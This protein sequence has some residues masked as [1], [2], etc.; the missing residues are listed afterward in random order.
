MSAASPSV[1]LNGPLRFL[2]SVRLERDAHTPSAL[3]GYTLTAQARAVLRRM[4]EALGPQGTERAWTLTGP[5]GSGKSAFALFLTQLLNAPTGEGYALLQ[6]ADPALADEWRRTTPRPFLP[7]ALTLRR[8][9][10]A[11]A[12][13]EGLQ[14]AAVA[15]SGADTDA[16][17]IGLAGLRAQG[18]TP[19]SRELLRQLEG[20]QGLAAAQGYGGVVLVLDELGKALEYAGRFEGEDIYL[21]QELAEVAARSGPRPLLF[22][23]VLHQAFEHYGEHLIAS[24]RKEWAKVQG[25]FADIA[26]L[27]PPEQQM[28]LAAQAMDALSIRPARDLLTQ[29]SAAAEGIAALG[30]APRALGNTEFL[31]LARSAAPLHPTVLLA[32]PYLFRRFAQNERSLFAYLLSGEPHAV[33]DLWPARAAL[34]RLADLFDYFALNLLGS[35]S[36]QAFARRWLEVV[37]AV[38]RH[39]DL[40]ELQVQTLKTVGLLGV[41]GDVS[42]LVPGAELISLALRDTAEDPEVARTL[43][44]LEHRS[45]IVYRRFNRT[46]RVWEGSDV[47]IEER[48]EEGRRSVG[49]Q[50]A[51]SEILER[52]LPRR[53]LVARRHSFDTGALR[54]FEIRYLDEPTDPAR[55][56]PAAGADGI[57]VCSL[58][59]SPEQGEA[60]ARW[61]QAD[62]LRERP[63]LVVV[64]PEQIHSLREA[65]T[66]LRALHWL[67]ESTPE[68]RDDRVARRE[69]AERLSHLETLLVTAVEQLLDPRPAPQGSHAAY[70]HLGE[71]VG[72]PTPRQAT[73]LLSA[74]M[75]A[76]YP[77]SPHVLNELVNRRT[78]SSAAA[79][80]RRTLIER[81]LTQAEEPLLGIE[82]YPPER[83]MYESVLRATGLHAPL[84]PEE[85]EGGWRFLE[86][87]EGH[88]THLAPTWARIGE[89]IFGTDEPL[90]VDLLFAQL[91][92]PP[93]GVTAGLQPVLLAAFMQAHPHEISLYREG[94]FVPEPS[95]ADFEVLLRRPELFAVAGSAVRGERADVLTRLAASLNTPEALVP[96]VRT[97]I[98]MVKGLHDTSWRTRRLPDE[99]L[100][101]RDAFERARSP[102]KLL[103]ADI[104]AAL[105][106]P[107]IGDGP[108]DPGRTATFFEALNGAIRIWAAHAPQQTVQARATLLEA[109]EFPATDEGWQALTEQ[110]QT[111]QGR[112]L[113]ASLVPLVN[114]LCSPGKAEAVLDGVLALVAGRSPRSWTDADADRFPTQAQAIAQTYGLA[115]RQLGYSSP[116]AE[117]ASE[118]YV[119]SLRASLG[120]TGAGPNIPARH[121]DAVKLALLRLLQELDAE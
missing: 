77:Q 30:Q 84:D 32:L 36:R 43:Q 31:S 23:G 16:W 20:L 66:E 80:A 109:L 103:F 35:L 74:A 78:L 5:Y 10:L 99:V 6:A 83:S 72:A 48:L 94:A 22:M 117:Q 25:R 50:L 42:T 28:R 46:F 119:Q 121:R 101:L 68:L 92:A 2:R 55:L 62:A 63:D 44:E 89:L 33:P 26:F 93:Y 21:L 49:A 40:S 75:D 14:E 82:G 37:D 53:P 54:F 15:L 120:L 115:A 11:V 47:D 8:A 104:P 4:L 88:A 58:P 110:A 39:P 114:R 81:M 79:A 112:P 73:Q 65:A 17:R 7:V 116:E 108:G 61:A 102:E 1:P 56:T 71:R 34:V 91:A 90:A 12:L 100:A 29:A 98:R 113:P 118:R 9:P 57:L 76:V 85:P 19:D 106:L 45:L 52:Y 3:E 51:L 18:S 60:F 96:V 24:A 107:A 69:V 13:L 87:Q 105:G 111:L 38:E 64:V 70:H 67:R 27:E 97:L 41:L 59:A 95:I 86:P